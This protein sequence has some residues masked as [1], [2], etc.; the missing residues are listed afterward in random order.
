MR[1][2][3]FRGVGKP[4]AIEQV[5]D[6]VPGSDQVIVEVV[7]SGICGSD[8]HMADN[9][10]T[11]Q[12]LIFG[13]EFAGRIVALG[14]GVGAA[15][16]I[17][18]HVTALP[19]N[20]CNDCSACSSGLPALCP[21]NHFVGTSLLAQ[22]G[23]A[24]F[25]GARAGM[26][27]RL[28]SGVTFDEGALVEPL[29]VGHHIVSMVSMPRDASVLIMGGGPIGI[30]V[31]LCALHAGA[32]H[33]VVSERSPERRALARTLGA[34]AAI[35]PGE[36]DLTIAFARATGEGRPKIIFECVGVP[37][38]LKQAIEIVDVRGQIIV[39]GVVLQEE[40][41]LPILALGK[42][43]TIRFSQA[44]TEHDFEAVIDLLARRE[45]DPAPIH[46]ST[47]R[48]DGLPD[49]FTALRELPSECKVLIRP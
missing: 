19:L 35:D 12:G 6:P 24:E 47:V 25:V 9:I 40:K 3:V 34:T 21:S 31:L 23:Y 46:T 42:E 5:E 11:P 8:L 14:A 18:D 45:I 4:L 20:A 2:A 36:E 7:R 29:A 10:H 1:A 13:H 16:K 30:A 44:Y 22:G 33:V 26:L 15:W 32:R 39:A 28:P 17:G 37:G 41:I 49:A 27:Q 48:L 43:V 38:L